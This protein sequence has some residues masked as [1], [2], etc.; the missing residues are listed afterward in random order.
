MAVYAIESPFLLYWNTATE[1]SAGKMPHG[2]WSTART[3]CPRGRNI[4]S[5]SST[6]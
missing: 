6:T 2:H 4:T 5:N 1:T 3:V